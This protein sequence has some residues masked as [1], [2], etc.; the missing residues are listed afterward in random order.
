M[1]KTA[2]NISMIARHHQRIPSFGRRRPYVM[3]G[4]AIAAPALSEDL[5]LFAATWLAGFV[6]VSIF[7]V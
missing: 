5:K 2:L 1:V 7:L 4:T 3:E 6:F